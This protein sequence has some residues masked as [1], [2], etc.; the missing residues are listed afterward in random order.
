[1]YCTCL[2]LAEIFC[3][4]F[5][6]IHIHAYFFF[7]APEIQQVTEQISPQHTKQTESVMSP[8]PQEAPPPPPS[9]APPPL[10]YS[11]LDVDGFKPPDILKR[12]QRGSRG[13][14]SDYSSSP[15]SMDS[16]G[17]KR[18]SSSSFSW[19][20]EASNEKNN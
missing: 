3:I 1:M 6:Y 5:T 18:L 4:H 17:E 8:E 14:R 10:K 16:D 9:A 11:N 19:Q 7:L 13:A 20:N 12:W 2:T 15:T